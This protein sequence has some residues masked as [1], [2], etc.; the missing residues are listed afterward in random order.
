MGGSDQAP[1]EFIEDCSSRCFTDCADAMEFM[2]VAEGRPLATYLDK[3]LLEAG[4]QR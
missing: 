4:R 1:T 3:H 2:A